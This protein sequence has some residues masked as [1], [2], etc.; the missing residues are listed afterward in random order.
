MWRCA[1]ANRPTPRVIARRLAVGVLTTCAT[2]AY[3]K[4]HGTPR[5][6][7]D[8]ATHNCL[9]FVVPDTR[10]A[11][12]WRFQRDGKRFAIAVSGNL[13]LDHSEALVQA[14]LA[15]TALIQISSYVTHRHWGAANSRRC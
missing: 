4:R 2:P 5:E 12:P 3:L 15:G 7:E 9:R 13:T 6:P 11:L 1:W 14:A 10:R 8:L